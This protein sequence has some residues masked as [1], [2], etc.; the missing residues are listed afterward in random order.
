MNTKT[1]KNNLASR[2]KLL[3]SNKK[4]H[5]KQLLPWLV[6]RP[7]LRDSLLL[8]SKECRSNINICKPLRTNKL[9]RTNS[10]LHKLTNK[11]KLCRLL[12]PKKLKWNKRLLL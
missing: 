10:Q 12:P 11:T 5:R 2:R 6:I 1:C 3:R 4:K 8:N 7:N 9:R